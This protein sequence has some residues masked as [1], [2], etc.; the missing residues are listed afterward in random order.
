MNP[1]NY[2]PLL[3]SS[4]KAHATFLKQHRQH[5]KNAWEEEAQIRKARGKHLHHVNVT[6]LGCLD[7]TCEG[8]PFWKVDLRAICKRHMDFSKIE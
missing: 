7:E 6:E 5:D 4:S 8:A 2:A 1:N 3:A